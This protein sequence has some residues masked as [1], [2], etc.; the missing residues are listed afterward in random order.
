MDFQKEIIKLLEKHVKNPTLEIPPSK[1]LGDYA[2]PCFPLAREY[3]K[4]PIE[5]AQDLHKKIK[6][7]KAIEKITVNGGYLNFFINKELLAEE[8]I[9]QILKE[10]EKYGN[11]HLGKNKTIVIDMSS[12][13]IAKP[14]GIGHLRSTI[15]GNSLSEIHKKLGFKTIKINYLGDWGTQFGKLIVGYKKF[16]SATKLKKN[17]IE[18]LLEVYV[19]ANSEEYE[20]EARAWFKKLELG[21]KE[22]L[23]LWKFFREL[24]IKEFDKIYKILGIKFD[25]NSGESYYNNKMQSTIKELKTKNLLEESEEALVVNLEKYNLEVCLIQKKDGTTLYATRDI[26]AAIDRY[27]KYKFEKMLYEVGSEQQLHF[28]QF[29]KVLELLGYKWAKNCIHIEHGLYLDKEGK[30]FATRKGKTVF[31][32]EILQETIDLAKKTIEKKNPKLKNKDEIARKIAIG[33]IFFGDLKNKR[34]NNIIFDIERFLDFEGDTGPYL[35]YSY[36]RANSILEKV[37]TKK[38]TFKLKNLEEPE[39]ELIKKLSAF[40][41]IV[42]QSYTHLNPAIIANYSTELAQNFNEFYHKCPVINSEYKEQRISIVKAF[43]YIIKESLSLLGI[44]TVQEM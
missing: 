39:I 16:G 44:E 43:M 27:K 18:H 11:S 35:Q 26:T 40:P 17:P 41:D 20:D 12:P 1:E 14:F 19:K 38:T 30:K 42:N 25:V 33:A 21:D 5:I 13:N 36:A 4:N 22:A 32:E 24:S 28:K 8:V 9:N 6:P 34:N 31:M 23:K 37:K 2:F 10:K 15:I 29:F 7:T 3:K